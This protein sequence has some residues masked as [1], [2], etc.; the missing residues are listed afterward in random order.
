ML[1][2]K[3][4]RFASQTYSK[5]IRILFEGFFRNFF[6]LFIKE[7]LIDIFVHIKDAKLRMN[8]LEKFFQF[9]FYNNILRIDTPIYEAILKILK[10]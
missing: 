5:I 7:V 1:F 3:K 10:L 9:L 8:L 4:I 6:V 2:G